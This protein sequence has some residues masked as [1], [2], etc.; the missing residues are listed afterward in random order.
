MN[1]E[2]FKTIEELT[3]NGLDESDKRFVLKLGK[4]GM[5]VHDKVKDKDITLI[6]IVNLLN[7]CE[8]FHKMKELE[9][10]RKLAAEIKDLGVEPMDR[11][12]YE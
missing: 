7:I 11:D 12:E 6:D 1:E 5:Y 10:K 2:K 9:L 8:V 3:N 4:Y